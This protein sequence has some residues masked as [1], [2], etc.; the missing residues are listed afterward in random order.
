MSL[1]SKK[2]GSVENEIPNKNYLIDVARTLQYT[3]WLLKILGVWTMVKKNPKP[4]EKYSWKFLMV[5]YTGLILFVMIPCTANI[6]L[7]EKNPVERAMLCGPIGF[8]ITN[9]LKYYFMFFRSNMIKSCIKNMEFDWMHIVTKNDRDIMTRN[10]NLGV[11]VTVVCGAFMYGGGLMYNMILPLS[12]GGHLNEFNE[13]IRPLVY[14]G[15][16]IFVD[17][18]KTPLYEII[19]Y[20]NCIVAWVTYTITTAACNLAAVFVA[21]TCGVIGIMMSRLDTLFEDVDERSQVVQDRLGY[22]VKTHVRV[23]K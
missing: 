11:D 19:F 18:Q 2:A 8:C 4:W 3:R 12:Q 9:L 16:D 6:I 20:T 23:L 1:E 15:Y 21:H 17:S 22:V 14:P 5:L 10:V 7:K 13:T